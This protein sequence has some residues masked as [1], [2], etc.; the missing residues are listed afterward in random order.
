MADRRTPSRLGICQVATASPD[1]WLWVPILTEAV[2]ILS[3]IGSKVTMLMT[4]ETALN[5]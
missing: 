4:P 5:P 1:V 3:R 2:F